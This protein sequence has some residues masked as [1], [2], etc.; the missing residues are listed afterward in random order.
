MEGITI[1]LTVFFLVLSGMSEAVMD[2]I[3][4]H[5][6]TSIFSDSGDNPF[7][8]NPAISWRNKYKNNAPE[9]GPAFFGSTTFLVF[10]TD[11]WHFMKFVR[12]SF[13]LCAFGSFTFIEIH[14][15]DA[16]INALLYWL[17]ILG[18]FFLRGIFF[19]ITFSRWLT[20]QS[21]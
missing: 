3:N 11:A 5:Y 6:E 15:G 21:N 1:C 12:N 14:T 17:V 18:G 8:W 19:E 10:L 13:L 4:F 2:K 20:K 7:F 16:F 9:N